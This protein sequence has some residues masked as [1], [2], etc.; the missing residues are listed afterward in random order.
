MLQMRRQ[1]R[2]AEGRGYIRGPGGE[3][4]GRVGERR[5][6]GEGE[7]VK[8]REEEGKGEEVERRS[9]RRR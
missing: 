3:R 6:G 2:S 9:L 7:R 5:G 1:H 4:E 8:E